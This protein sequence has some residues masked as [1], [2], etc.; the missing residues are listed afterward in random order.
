M[1][2]SSKISTSMALFIDGSAPQLYS[3]SSFLR[4]DDVPDMTRFALNNSLR[5]PH[6]LYIKPDRPIESTGLLYRLPLTD[7]PLPSVHTANVLGQT[8]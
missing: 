4:N 5:P 2:I 3:P 7:F 8:I 6:C 1:I